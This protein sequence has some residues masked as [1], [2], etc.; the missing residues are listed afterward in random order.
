[1]LNLSDFSKKRIC[2]AVSGG[3]DSVSLLHYLRDRETQYGYRLFAVHLEHGIRGEESLADMRFVQTLCEK[4]NIPLFTFAENCT[5]RAEREKNSLETAARNFRY[6][7]FAQLVKEDKVD[8]IALAHHQNDEAETV[9]FRIARGAALSGAKGMVEQNGYLL[10]PFLSWKKSEIVEYAKAHTLEYCID[11][12]NFEL[13]ATRNK[14]RLSVL[15]LL[16]EIVPGAT[17]H[18][19]RFATLAA[20]DD[21]YLYAEGERLIEK[22]KDGRW[23]VAFSDAKPLFRRACLTVLKALGVVRD[24]TA[25]HLESAFALQGLERGAYLCLPQ[26]VIAKKTAEGIVFY[27]QEDEEVFSLEKPSEKPFS[28]SGFDGGRYEVSVYLAMPNTVQDEWKILALDMDKLPQSAVFRFRREGDR[29]ERFGGGTKSLKK[30]FNEKKIPVEE[31]EWLP[32]IAEKD[33]G[34]VYAVCGVEIAD[35][36]KI[37]E[38]TER[39]VYVAVKRK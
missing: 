30:F 17:E 13:C 28:K 10:R 7:K 26:G 29:I 9:L 37:T 4:W 8:Y 38:E 23:L 27:L 11:K 36:V 24:Y 25:A 35:E 39:V 6:E 14:L 12:T 18:I 20:E 3:V 16:E 21:G 33:S 22:D 1:M 34:V 19:A 15:P 5:M 2:V 32:L 31:R